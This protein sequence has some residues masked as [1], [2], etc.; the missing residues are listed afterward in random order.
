MDWSGAWDKRLEFSHPSDA[1]FSFALEPLRMQ[2]KFQRPTLLHL[3]QAIKTGIAGSLVMLLALK[4]NLPQPYWSAI[5][6]VVVMQSEY[7]ATV[8]TGLSQISG[9]AIGALVIVP[10][11]ELMQGNIVAF[12]VA[13]VVTM[14]I[15]AILNLEDSQRLAC[16]TVALIMLIGHPEAPW[17]EGLQRFSEVTF[18]ILVSLAVT[19]LIWPQHSQQMVE[20]KQTAIVE[21]RNS[22]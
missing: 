21:K 14:L 6:A 15:C 18:G 11:A 10:F 20:A 8:K 1:V 2:I 12:F 3:K 9:T 19:R 4:F 7:E 13:L 16:S 17:L 5:T 22:G